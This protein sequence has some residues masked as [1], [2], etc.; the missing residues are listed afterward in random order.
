MEPYNVSGQLAEVW[1]P[2]L[3]VLILV[4]VEWWT[5]TWFLI[6]W[7]SVAVILLGELVFEG[8]DFLSYTFCF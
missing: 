1:V 2:C 4:R 3:T 8:I 6:F 7:S 5:A